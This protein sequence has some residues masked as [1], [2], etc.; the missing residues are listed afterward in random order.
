MITTKEYQAKVQLR[1]YHNRYAKG[2]QYL[3]KVCFIKE[4]FLFGILIYRSIEE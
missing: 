4:V 2:E 1:V 3:W